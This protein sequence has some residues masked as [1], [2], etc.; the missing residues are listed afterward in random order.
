MVTVIVG[1][2]TPPAP[3]TI[4][5]TPVSASVSPALEVVK[6]LS[7]NTQNESGSRV[8]VLRQDPEGDRDGKGASE[9]SPET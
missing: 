1:A 5:Q 4:F 6:T 7:E 3:V 2:K 9:A 8:G